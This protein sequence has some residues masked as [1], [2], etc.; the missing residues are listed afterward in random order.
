M[1][2]QTSIKRA[3]VLAA[4]LGE[5]MRPLTDNTPKPLL[6]LQG[7]SLIDYA[8]DRLEDAGIESVVVNTFYLADQMEEHLNNR[9][10]P[11]IMV[12]R[13]KERLETGGGVLNALPL[14]GDEPFFVINGD[15]FWLNGPTDALGRMKELWIGDHMDALLMMHPTVD[16]YG[17]N[18]RGDFLVEP[19]GLLS[20]RPEGEDCPYMFAGVQILHPRLFQ[21]MPA[22]VFSLNRLYDLA[23]ENNRLHGMVHDGEWFH[24]GTPEGLVETEAFMNERYSDERYR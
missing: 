1:Q 13:E 23:I 2:K 20:R 4:G 15:A 7:S 3:M 22:G 18:G 14:L 8:L 12:S 6:K 10:H 19:G 16:A 17:Y 24:I 11:E 9:P 5:R 21:S